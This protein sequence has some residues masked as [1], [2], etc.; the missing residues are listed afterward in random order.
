[1]QPGSTRAQVNKQTFPNIRY[2]TAGPV[3]WAERE[4]FGWAM[5][6]TTTSSGQ[7]KAAKGSFKSN[8]VNYCKLGLYNWKH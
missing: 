2:V 6:R 4:H 5:V 8:L 7:P 3:P 1:M